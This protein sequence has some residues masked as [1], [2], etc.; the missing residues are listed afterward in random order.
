VVNFSIANRNEWSSSV[1]CPIEERLIK[2]AARLLAKQARLIS[3]MTKWPQTVAESLN[4][5]DPRRAIQARDK[6]LE[7][8]ANDWEDFRTNHRHLE[9]DPG[10]ES[11]TYFAND[12]YEVASMAYVKRA[13]EFEAFTSNS[14]YVVLQ[15]HSKGITPSS[16][17]N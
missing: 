6:G 17:A 9:D 2:M 14:R 15:R 11:A 12:D 7:I 13:A 1:S 5:D 4:Y 16:P 10:I 8:L 3:R